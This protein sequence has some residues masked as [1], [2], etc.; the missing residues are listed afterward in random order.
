MNLQNQKHNFKE[1]SP[2]KCIETVQQ[3]QAKP[4][5]PDFKK[6]VETNNPILSSI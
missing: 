6:Q 5:K 4:R 1:L 3:R 2:N